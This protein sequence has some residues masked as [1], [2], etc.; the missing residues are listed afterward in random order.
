MTVRAARPSVILAGSKVRIVSIGR[1][2]HPLVISIANESQQGDQT[3]GCKKPV[4]HVQVLGLAL[5]A[6]ITYFKYF[7]YRSNQMLK[8]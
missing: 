2:P 5:L 8:Q 3:D 4:W 7:N 6:G 1:D